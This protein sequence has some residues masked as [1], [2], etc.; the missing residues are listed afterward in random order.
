MWLPCSVFPEGPLPPVP[1]RRPRCSSRPPVLCPMPSHLPWAPAGRP[2]PGLPPPR[3]AQVGPGA[4]LCAAPRPEPL[5]PR[6]APRGR[7]KCRRPGNRCREGE[8]HGAGRGG[9]TKSRCH[10][11]RG[12][13][14]PS[15]N[16]GRREDPGGTSR[17]P[18]AFAASPN[19]R[20]GWLLTRQLPRH[21]AEI[22]G[23]APLDHP[24]P[25]PKPEP[26]I[27]TCP[28]LAAL[29]RPRP[30]DSKPLAALK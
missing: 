26:E 7:W 8:P 22:T 23:R 25:A 28:L 27:H 17:E 11:R 14:R 1:A 13:M 20:R 29:Q 18:R 30:D 16:G 15:S 2:C 9:R 5:L 10:R 24:S 4:L 3:P 21:G 19:A 6:A 12:A